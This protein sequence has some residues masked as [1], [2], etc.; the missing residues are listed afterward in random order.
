MQAKLIK[1]SG[2]S[3]MAMLLQS[4]AATTPEIRYQTKIVDTS[5]SWVKPITI[6]VKDSI[7]DRT[8]REVLTHNRLVARN[9]P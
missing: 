8:A 6:S 1:M 5:C 7:T 3:A 2:I 4:C 9:C